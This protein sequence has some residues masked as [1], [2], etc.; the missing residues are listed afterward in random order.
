M[1]FSRKYDFSILKD[2]QGRYR[3]Q[4]LFYETSSSSE[5]SEAYPPLFTTKADDHKGFLSLKKIYFS[6]DHIPGMEYE[7]ALEVF[8][9]WDQWIKLSTESILRATIAEWREE[10]DIR[11]KANA[12]K[13][14]LATSREESPRGLQAARYMADRGY[15]VKRGRPSKA[16]TERERK[17]AAGVSADL[18]NDMERLGLTIVQGSK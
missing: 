9:S 8:N 17:V 12:I 1:S 11:L 14:I 16:E 15:Q 13:S 10:L 2:P 3:T 6:Y 7:F 5:F 4:S 18:Q